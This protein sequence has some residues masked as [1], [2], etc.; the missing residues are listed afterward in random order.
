[1]IS[2]RCLDPG[3]YIVRQYVFDVSLSCHVLCIDENTF[4]YEDYQGPDRRL[5]HF[6]DWWLQANYE[7]R[8]IVFRS[9]GTREVQEPC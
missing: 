6:Q 2:R 8:V 3:D 1:M 4:Y 5:T 7:V 9:D